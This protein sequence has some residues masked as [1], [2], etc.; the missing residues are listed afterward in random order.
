MKTVLPLK[1]IETIC[2]NPENAEKLLELFMHLQYPE[3]YQDKDKE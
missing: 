2:S 1:D 3:L